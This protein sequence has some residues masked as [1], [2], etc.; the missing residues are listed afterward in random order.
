MKPSGARPAKPV[1]FDTL[2]VLLPTAQ[3]TWLLRACLQSDEAGR[4]AWETWQES[5]GD[6]KRALAD[7]GQALKWLLP[8]LYRALQTNGGA[9][10][11]DLMPY[12]RT[13]YFREE[14]RSQTYR[15]ICSEVLAPLAAA[16]I[17]LLVLDGA[18]LAESAYRDWA[19]RHSGSLDL[20][21]Q[22]DDLLRAEAALEAAGLTTATTSLRAGTR[23]VQLVHGSGLPVV[24]RSVLFPMPY[25][26]VPLADVWRRSLARPI[27]GVPVRILSPADSLLHV[28]GVASCARSRETLQWVCDS[29]ALVD[30]FPDLDW[31]GLLAGALRSH[32][33]LPLSVMLGYLADELHAPI[34][35]SALE[36]L[37][38]ASVPASIVACE[39]ALSGA[40][41]TSRGTMTN[42]LAHS[43]SWLGRAIVLKWRFL[44][45][46]TCLR[47]TYRVRSRWLLPVYYLYRP[48]SVLTGRSRSAF[49]SLR[50]AQ[51][52]DLPAG[53]AGAPSR[54][55]APKRER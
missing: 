7:E 52:P 46:P 32:L 55:R 2:S 40:R 54:S 34:P 50:T 47:W 1:L 19:L 14:L 21:V 48:L 24:L 31:D 6:P 13:A 30:Q 35:T 27:A 17:P 43:H 53:A 22:E 15:R 29:W 18:A 45:S 10:S 41:A 25:Y 44:P 4:R 33:A 9:V 37:L 38:V 11:R 16:E 49:R 3:Q 42:L 12:L 39:A 36:D 26:Q 20:L 8:L 5:V 23:A 28:C 51:Q